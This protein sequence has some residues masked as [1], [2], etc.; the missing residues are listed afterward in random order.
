MAQNLF[1]GLPPKVF[2]KTKLLV[3]SILRLGRGT[4]GCQK[5]GLLPQ[6]RYRGIKQDR[7]MLPC[8]V[9]RP[10]QNRRGPG[11]QRGLK[12]KAGRRKPKI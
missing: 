8:L 12:N 1:N 7:R 2:C 6:A 4:D 3:L 11:T 10:G 9:W 5:G